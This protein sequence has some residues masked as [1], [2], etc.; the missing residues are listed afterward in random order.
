MGQSQSFGANHLFCCCDL[1]HGTSRATWPCW[2][3]KTEQ[4]L[5][6]RNLF[7][8]R[9]W[10]HLIGLFQK[11]SKWAWGAG[12][13]GRGWGYTFLKRPTGNFRFVTLLLEIPEK[14]KFYPWK[15]CKFLWHSLKIPKPKT[16]TH[17][18]YTLVFLEH[19]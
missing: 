13:G 11:K 8:L 15:F 5:E 4:V 7:I 19:P 3:P 16:K 18:N 1:T 9:K 12:E 10:A 6:T 14:I 2:I 17:W